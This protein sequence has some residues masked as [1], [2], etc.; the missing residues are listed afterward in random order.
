MFES[1]PKQI[2]IL[3]SR[4]SV[5]TTLLLGSVLIHLE[6]LYK[7]VMH[8]I[9]TLLQKPHLLNP[10]TE[11]SYLPTWFVF[12]SSQ[13]STPIFFQN[14]AS[15]TKMHANTTIFIITV[16]PTTSDKS[17]NIPQSNWELRDGCA[18]LEWKALQCRQCPHRLYAPTILQFKSQQPIELCD[19]S[20][21]PL[22]ILATLDPQLRQS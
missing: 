11:Q 20:W 1:N 2:H 4:D 18:S 6:G 21:K 17:G 3:E 10:S 15:T 14:L 12:I 9:W 13:E 5:Y 19:R 8:C 16:T 22:Q 7:N